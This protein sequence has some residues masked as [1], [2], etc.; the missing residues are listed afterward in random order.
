MVVKEC[1][2]YEQLNKYRKCKECCQINTGINWCRI[3]WTSNNDID[4]FI[5]NVQVLEWITYDGFYD[6]EYNAKGGFGTVYRE[7]WKDEEINYWNID[8]F[9]VLK[10]LNISQN[11]TLEFINEVI[12]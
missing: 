2:E 6:V 8:K 9:I 5:Q 10:C 1:A 11:V 3:N 7:K 12:N 4:K